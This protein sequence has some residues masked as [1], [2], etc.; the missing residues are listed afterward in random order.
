MFKRSPLLNFIKKI[1]LQLRIFISCSQSLIII[2]CFISSK[3]KITNNINLLCINTER[4]GDLVLST[5]FLF[6]L[7]NHSCYQMKYL[8]IQDIYVSLFDW[9][10]IGF[11]PLPINKTKYKKNLLY[12]L[13]FIHE[14]RKQEF[15][16][17]INFTPERGWIND[18]LVMTS[19]AKEKIALKSSSIYLSSVILKYINKKYSTIYD[20][21]IN[22]EYNKLNFLL[23]YYR[24]EKK[25]IKDALNFNDEVLT[26]ILK[27]VGSR[28][29]ICISPFTSDNKR[30]WG[31]NNFIKLAT[32][33]ESTLNFLIL[34]TK[35]EINSIQAELQNASISMNKTNIFTCYDKDL[36]KIASIIRN[37]LIFIGNDSGLTHIAHNLEVPTI[38][39]IGGGEYGRFFP[40]KD[41]PNTYYFYHQLDCFGCHWNCIYK[42][43]YCL[44]NI[45]VEMVIDKIK[46]IIEVNKN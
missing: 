11:S 14:I 1:F 6:C 16:T 34:G 42:E 10:K 39:I 38:A 27:R 43:K 23:E 40:Y 3:K 44:T 35:N 18:E 20:Y 2:A 37:S 31:I 45:S 25:I 41:N 36:G 7:G 24:I 21:G 46:E 32:Y 30:T 33:F 12:R 4:L 19:V 22:N 5:D 17:I 9:E 8:L 28:K 13:L 15:L 26:S 29:Y